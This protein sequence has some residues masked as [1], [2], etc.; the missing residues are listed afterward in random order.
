[1]L[2]QISHNRNVLL[3]LVCTLSRDPILHDIAHLWK[4]LLELSLLLCLHLLV[5]F[6]KHLLLIIK[7][8]V[9]GKLIFHQKD[10]L[11]FL[12]LQVEDLV[13]CDSVLLNV[14]G[15]LEVGIEFI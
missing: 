15:V 11:V 14:A 4:D 7:L 5:V 12:F 2:E 10:S 1:M 9:F 8:S 3:H 13:H 6:L